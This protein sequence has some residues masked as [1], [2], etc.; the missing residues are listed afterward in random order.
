MSKNRHRKK[1]STNAGNEDDEEEEN[2]KTVKVPM[3]KVLRPAFRALITA[4]ITEKS[5]EAMKLCYLA[6]LLFY[7]KFKRH[8]IQV[9]LNFL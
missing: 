8:L 9:M 4:A 5:I 2:L 6:S 3:K 1:I 7:I